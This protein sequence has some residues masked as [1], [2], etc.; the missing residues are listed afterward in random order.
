MILNWKLWVLIVLV[1]LVLGFALVQNKKCNKEGARLGVPFRCKLMDAEPVTLIAEQHYYG[2]RDGKCFDIIDYGS[3]MSFR[4]VNLA[5]C[6]TE[7]EKKE[8]QQRNNIAEVEY[9]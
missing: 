4:E 8:R 5:N 7:E 3:N 9:F 6:E 1:I 2:K